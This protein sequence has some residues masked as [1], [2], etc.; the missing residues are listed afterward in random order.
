MFNDYSTVFGK[1]LSPVFNNV[2]NVVFGPNIRGIRGAYLQT[3]DR[4]V[5]VIGGVPRFVSSDQYAS[6]FTFQWERFSQTQLDSSQ[7][8]NLTLQD[9]VAKTQV[10]PESLRG[11]VVLDV[12]VG[13]GRHA[14]YFC[15]AGA[16]VIGIDLSESV[17]QAHS[18]LFKYPNAVV[19]QADLFD[20]PFQHGV[21]DLVY[22]IGVLHHTPSWR[23][24]LR[25]ISVFPKL[26]S[27]LFSI[28]LYGANFSRRDEWVR[29]TNQIEPEMFLNLC[30]LLVAAHRGAPS[31]FAMKNELMEVV[32][33]HFPFSVHHPNFERSL[34]A[35][36]DGYSPAF[37]A[38]TTSL[39][40]ASEMSSLGYLSRSGVVEASAAGRRA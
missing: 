18:N 32:L 4:D 3:G 15:K 26:A 27:G 29:F 22:S 11:K 6:S 1:P 19:L 14:E 23:D 17:V 13:I 8:V 30:R 5:P 35:L 38:V 24:A 31:G 16:F 36:F 28:W 20:L 7:G 10:D 2:L 21:F 33:R 34:L 40:I 37:H 39:E 9:L 12:G 25:A